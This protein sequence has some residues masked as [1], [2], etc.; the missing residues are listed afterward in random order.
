MDFI[1]F[2]LACIALLFV[3]FL[4]NVIIE[5]FVKTVFFFSGHRQVVRYLVDIQTQLYTIVRQMTKLGE[6]Q[7]K[8]LSCV[9]P[10]LETNISED[11][12]RLPLNNK[13]GENQMNEI[14]KSTEQFNKV[15]C[16]IWHSLNLPA[17]GGIKLTNFYFQVSFLHGLGG[18]SPREAVYSVCKSLF[19][20]AFA[21]TKSM[22]GIRRSNN[23]AK[24]AFMGT[25]LFK[26]LMC[27]YNIQLHIIL[28]GDSRCNNDTRGRN[29]TPFSGHIP[30]LM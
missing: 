23:P 11:L 19:T 1:C 12:P 15:V 30:F 6:S 22:K 9:L 27:E 14:M 28:C 17:H 25:T 2:V 3:M 13:V 10:P 18:S 4:S 24:D 29:R 16:V 7:G 20:D 5:M 8:I 21:S 26:A